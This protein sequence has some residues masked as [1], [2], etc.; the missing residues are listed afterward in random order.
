M[1]HFHKGTAIGPT[2]LHRTGTAVFSDD[3]RFRYRLERSRVAT[4]F[5]QPTGTAVFV[6]LNP[7]VADDKVDDPTLLQ[8]KWF[9]FELMGA[10][11]LIVVNLYAFRA[12][13]PRDLVSAQYPVGPDNDRHIL[14][15]LNEANA[16]VVVAWGAKAQKSRVQWLAD[17]AMHAGKPLWCLEKNK[18]GS[19]RHPLYV[20]RSTTLTRRAA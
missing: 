17:Q 15:A 7:S 10:A 2:R 20:S 4:L 11:K 1:N 14:G 6:M 19:P 16:G 3:Y 5:N 9:A 8:C 13:D 18:D 12:T